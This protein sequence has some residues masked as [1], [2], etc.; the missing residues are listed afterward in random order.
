MSHQLTV[1]RV[2]EASA[3]RV[4]D[5]YIDPAA[6]KVWMREGQ[7]PGFVL[8]TEC[9]P[10]VGGTWTA[11]WGP[12]RNELYSETNVFEVL[13]RPRRIVTDTVTS[14][15]DGTSVHTRIEITFEEQDGKTRM[16][17][18]QT[19]FESAG[20]RD[21]FATVAWPGAFDQLD[22]YLTRG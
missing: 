5:A 7:E 19:G 15:Y 22:R 12:S 3:E 6:Q 1:D 20:A 17:V 14:S 21:F 16:T 18:H 2:F 4:F 13:D 9:D 8:E 10:R 11:T